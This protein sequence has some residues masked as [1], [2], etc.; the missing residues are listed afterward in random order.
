MACNLLAGVEG[1]AEV[2]QQHI[3]MTLTRGR[4]QKTAGLTC[5]DDFPHS[6]RVWFVGDVTGDVEFGQTAGH[7]GEAEA[8]CA[9]TQHRHVGRAAVRL[10]VEPEVQVVRRGLARVR[11]QQRAVHLERRAR[12][13]QRRIIERQFRAYLCNE[14]HTRLCAV[15]IKRNEHEGPFTPCVSVTLPSRLPVHTERVYSCNVSHK[16]MYICHTTLENRDMFSCS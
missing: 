8:S 10:A 14:T 3:R 2:G 5:N 12:L 16:D 6:N 11:V 1:G 4:G 15:S 7:V 13:H 9:G